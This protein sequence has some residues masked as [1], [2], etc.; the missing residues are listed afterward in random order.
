MNTTDRQW[1]VIAT[2]WRYGQALW[3]LWKKLRNSNR[4]E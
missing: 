2:L 3:R 4:R 1:R